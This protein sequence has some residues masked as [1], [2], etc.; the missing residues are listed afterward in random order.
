MAGGTVQHTWG[1][2]ATCTDVTGKMDS[3]CGLV[4]HNSIGLGT[5][6]SYPDSSTKVTGTQA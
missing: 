1:C 5:T 6:G 3:Q 4:A 2:D